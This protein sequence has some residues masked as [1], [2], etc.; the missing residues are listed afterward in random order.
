MNTTTATTAGHVRLKFIRRTCG[1][2]DWHLIDFLGMKIEGREY[3][4]TTKGRAAAGAEA[5][6]AKQAYKESFT[7]LTRGCQPQ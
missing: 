2:W 1:W 7:N 4:G 5:K 3:C 6:A